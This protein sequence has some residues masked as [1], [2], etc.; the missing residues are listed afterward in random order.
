MQSNFNEITLLH[1]CSPVN[2]LHIFTTVSCKIISRGLL[3]NIVTNKREK[4]DRKI[5]CNRNY[6]FLLFDIFISV[7]FCPY[8]KIQNCKGYRGWLLLGIVEAKCSGNFKLKARYTAEEK[9]VL[10]FCVNKNYCIKDIIN[11]INSEKEKRVACT[12][13]FFLMFL[14]DAHCIREK[15]HVGVLCK[16][17]Y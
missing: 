11:K 17:C 15:A 1:G 12:K 2:M 14:K 3:L 4:G 5:Q 7:P 10:R 8:W 16:G 6:V 13:Y 9:R